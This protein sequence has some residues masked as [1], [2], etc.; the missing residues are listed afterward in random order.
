M[1]PGR[2]RVWA[3]LLTVYVVWGSTYLA[4][5][6]A[7]QVFPPFLMA[8]SRFV[9][10][11]SVLLAVGWTLARRA[12]D[13]PPSRRQWGSVVVLGFTLFAVGN[14]A[15][16]WAQQRLTSGVASLVVCTVPLWMALFDR[17]VYRR[18]L[19]ALTITGVVAGFAGAAL[20]AAPGG[21]DQVDALGVLVLVA[22][23]AAWAV[24]SLWSRRAPLP[25]Q[26]FLGMG[27]QML[28]GAGFLALAAAASG[29][30]GQVHDVTALSVGGIAYLV[31]IGSLVGFTLYAWLLRTAP[32]PLVSTY[33]FA[34]P[35]VAVLLGWGVEHER[36]GLRTVGAAV[37]IIAAV[38][39]I[40]L[41]QARESRAAATLGS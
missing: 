23:S 6:Y 12:G 21:A 11:G 20:L 39:L 17:I 30:A 19:S 35:V 27:L 15:V 22:G 26:P 38:G 36:L 41:A 9:A 3:A 40:V 32:T 4:N 24:G 2:S 10:A 16:A 34:N 25:R 18:R 13:A 31:V 33:A 37:L 28:V 29:D 5:H 7:L 1:G 14:G 8:S